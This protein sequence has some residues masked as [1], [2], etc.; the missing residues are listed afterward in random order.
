[1]CISTPGKS[2]ISMRSFKSMIG[3]AGCPELADC[4]PECLKMPLGTFTSM[5]TLVKQMPKK[6]SSYE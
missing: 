6:P 4:I 3:S 1:M 2:P 5:A